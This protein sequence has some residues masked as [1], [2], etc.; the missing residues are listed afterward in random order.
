LDLLRGKVSD[1]LRGVAPS[2]ARQTV[3]DFAAE[4]IQTQLQAFDWR[5][6]QSDSK[7]SR[8]PPGFLLSAIRRE[9]APPREF[10]SR[11]DQTRRGR[12]APGDGHR[13]AD[14]RQKTETRRE[15]DE[16]RRDTAITEFWNSQSQ[17]ERGRLETEAIQQAPAF[18]RVLLEQD[19]SARDAARKAI[20][21]A[22]LL[23][24]L[25]SRR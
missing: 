21:D 4:Q 14:R 17:E 3:R 9:Y 23:K 24:L 1:V 15:A 11:G 13:V 12:T 25:R 22:H 20:L 19:G 10:L 7:I 6:A 8:N 2:T 5:R 16:R 18:Q